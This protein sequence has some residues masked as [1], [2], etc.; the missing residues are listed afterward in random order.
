MNSSGPSSRTAAVIPERSTSPSCS[1]IAEAS[2]GN[3]LPFG[4][5]RSL[6]KRPPF[7]H[8]LDHPQVM[9]GGRPSVLPRR[10]KPQSV[11][12]I[13]GSR[14]AIGTPAFEKHCGEGN[15][16]PRKRHAVVKDA[17]AE[18]TERGL[19]RE[20]WIMSPSCSL[21]SSGIR[22]EIISANTA[23]RGRWA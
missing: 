17:T 2:S 18:R 6:T 13:G 5:D 23:A 1:G 21:A 7:H 8:L 14:A 15:G 12:R 9:P 3:S 11:I 4:T 16:C 22:T 19:H 10:L 20:P